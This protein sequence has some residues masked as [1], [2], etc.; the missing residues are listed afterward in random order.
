MS[1]IFYCP[2]S[3]TNK[4]EVIDKSEIDES[5]FTNYH[6]RDHESKLIRDINELY[7]NGLVTVT[8][9]LLGGKGGFGSLLRAFGK[10]IVISK[11]RL[12]CRDLTGRRFRDVQNEKD[13]KKWFSNDPKE[14][15]EEE[16]GN[17]KRKRK[18][19]DRKRRIG[20]EKEREEL[21]RQ[22]F[23]EENER[24]DV[25]VVNDLLDTIKEKNESIAT[26]IDEALKNK[27]NDVD[28]N[29]GKDDDHQ[30]K[31]KRMKNDNWIG[32]DDFVFVNEDDRKEDGDAQKLKYSFSFPNDEIGPNIVRRL[33]TRT[34][35]K[36]EIDPLEYGI[37][38][39]KC[40]SSGHWY[41]SKLNKSYCKSLT[42]KCLNVKESMMNEK[43]LNEFLQRY[44]KSLTI[45]ADHM[46]DEERRNWL[47]DRYEEL[48]D[49]NINEETLRN[50]AI[51]MA[52]SEELD[53][54]MGKKFPSLKRYS[55]EGAEGSIALLHQLFKS[56]HD[57][58]LKKCVIGAVHR[59]RC[60]ILV[61]LLKYDPC[62]M[63][64]KI[65]G[66][67]EFPAHIT[68]NNPMITGDVL[69]HLF[70]TNDICGVE[71]SLIPNPSH[72]ELVSPV[73]MGKTRSK[74]GDASHDDIFNLQI[75][76]DAAFAG[77]GVIAEM[78]QMS[79]LKGF[80][81]NG[82]IHVIVN[83]ELGFATNVKDGRSSIFTS[84]TAK[85]SGKNIPVI[86]VDGEN[87][88]MILKAAQLAVEY[89]KKFKNDII[90]DMVC[91]RK[92]GHNE[93]DEPSFTQPK[94][95]EEI[96]S[97]ILSI[98]QTIC[99]NLKKRK[100]L[101]ENN[102]KNEILKFR[103][104]L[105]ESLDECENVNPTDYS[106]KKKWSENIVHPK[107]G[108]ITKW[109]TGCRKEELKMITSMSVSLG[110]R[111]IERIV[112]H[113][114]IMKHH[115]EKR[116]ERSNEK[117]P[118]D[119]ATAEACAIGS[120]MMD[121]HNVR[122]SG[123]DC[124]RGTFAQR[125][126]TLI[127]QQT[128]ECHI[129]LN[130]LLCEGRLEVCNSLLSE[131]AV[132][133]FEFGHSLET[134]KQL[135]IW[136][137]Q[138]GDFFNG[139]QAV[140]DTFIA[141]AYSKWLLQ[142]ALVLLLPH[143]YEG[144]G[145]E[146]TSCRIERFLQLTNSQQTKIDDDTINIQI[147]NPSTPSQ[148]FHLLRRQIE[149]NFR[150][151]LIIPTPKGMLRHPQCIS[152]YEEM[153]MGTKFL[154]VIP[155]KKNSKIQIKTII[156]VSGRHYYLVKE[157]L[158]DYNNVELIRLEQL[159]PFP[160]M[161]LHDILSKFENCEKIIWS[162]EEPENGGCWSFIDARF[163]HL[164]RTKIHYHGRPPI[165]APAVGIGELHKKEVEKLKT[166]LLELIL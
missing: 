148:Y 134:P 145:P 153:S 36:E 133:A 4:Y 136:E 87:L 74:M 130:D 141:S 157:L 53:I 163:R 96:R 107:K 114:T 22:K 7:P 116:L 138:F 144:M 63:F 70:L 30:F 16:N 41:S 68:E 151:P 37:I 164:L 40:R 104:F 59:G 122:L 51:L 90:I 154:P 83:N 14:E 84:D 55:G 150:T 109:S 135:T 146:H 106:L 131:E 137:A 47:W 76:G 102:L 77:Q 93:L 115:I 81:V 165:S 108:E 3:F 35:V 67:S 118:I 140:I 11:N 9:R 123:Q 8:P 5:L 101:N 75:H 20:Q 38:R 159:V 85:L 113:S 45:E 156:L 88:E 98:P 142:S 29:D 91:M 60:N 161:E 100:I 155:E 26:G 139:A 124:G 110:D 132:L 18:R 119:W 61:N 58:G 1:I 6:V 24:T 94:T 62:L 10:G 105:N 166:N 17:K 28:D 125:H 71:C 52:K 2:F 21:E 56:A 39:D 33:S 46:F 19:I 82:S 54:F 27:N 99:E 121:G 79:D 86:R 49:E 73:S 160:A 158:A 147:S 72:L 97:R 44:S 23:N 103:N 126:F 92:W 65:R 80:N 64:R 12:A 95:Y 66:M 78:I 32:M 69:S 15:E 143:G 34:I 31:R 48:F 42:L 25:D 89:R 13:I 120:L 117:L 43:I 128:E 112:P 129:P 57:N 162:Q 111:E 127:D 149:R 50:S 152:T